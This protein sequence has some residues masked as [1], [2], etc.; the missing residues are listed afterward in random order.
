MFTEALN[1][2]PN[3]SLPLQIV[4]TGLLNVHR[5]TCRAPNSS[6][7]LQLVVTGV[8]QLLIT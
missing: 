7:P 2:A 4:A 6:L 8:L 3:S 1:R 5:G